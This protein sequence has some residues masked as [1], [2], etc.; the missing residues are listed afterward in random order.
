MHR[1]KPVSA[2]SLLRSKFEQLKERCQKWDLPGCL[3]QENTDLLMETAVLFS[4]AQSRQTQLRLDRILE[5]LQTAGSKETEL[6]HECGLREDES[7]LVAVIDVAAGPAKF[8]PPPEDLSIQWSSRPENS[9]HK[10][11]RENLEHELSC[12]P[13]GN[14]TEEMSE[15][16]NMIDT[17]QIKLSKRPFLL[18]FLIGQKLVGF[19]KD[20][21]PSRTFVA[22]R[23][24]STTWV[25]QYGNL[26]VKRVPNMI[27]GAITTNSK[28]GS[29]VIDF[30]RTQTLQS[31]QDPEGFLYSQP[32]PKHDPTEPF[33]W[34]ACCWCVR[35]RNNER[36]VIIPLPTLPTTTFFRL[37]T[38]T[39]NAGRLDC[40][41][42]PKSI[43][44]GDQYTY[45]C[46]GPDLVCQHAFCVDCVVPGRMVGK[47]G[48]T[49]VWWLYCLPCAIKEVRGSAIDPAILAKKPI[50]IRATKD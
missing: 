21:F 25:D 15:K 5:R 37:M 31:W 6:D 36:K 3:N 32:K 12:P 48:K 2:D 39:S 41:G 35:K 34:V 27:L 38:R 9:E 26:K 10:M 29:V 47:G 11:L 14:E 44:C 24:P 28:E 20:Y 49:G 46:G 16:A 40:F 8:G 17:S 42:C 45:C 33:S 7:Q 22:I 18:R 13:D 30:E 1:T 4:K 19:L 43:Q 50:L 23:L